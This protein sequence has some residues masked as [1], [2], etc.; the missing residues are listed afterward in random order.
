M[1]TDP[2]PKPA[3]ILVGVKSGK[4]I[5]AAIIKPI[6]QIVIEEKSINRL[7]RL[8]RSLVFCSIRFAMLLANLANAYVINTITKAINSCGITSIAPRAIS[9]S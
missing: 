6:I 8:L 1:A 7:I 9:R 5:M 2:I 4:A 3:S